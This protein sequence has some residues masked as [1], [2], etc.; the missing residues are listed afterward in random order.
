M[1]HAIADGIAL[2]RVLLSLTDSDG[3]PVEFAPR[4]TARRRRRPAHLAGLARP[5]TAAISASR[6]LAHEGAEALLHPER[7]DS[8]AHTV[9]SDA[10]AFAKFLFPGPTPTAP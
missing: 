10:R 5:A 2:G 6:V 8:L 1:H 4:L 9:E 3:Q 7:L